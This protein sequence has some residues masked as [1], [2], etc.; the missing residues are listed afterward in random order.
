[1]NILAFDTCFDA[2][3]VAVGEGLGSASPRIVEFY[4]PMVKGQAERLIPMIREALAAASLGMAEIDRIAVTSG[5]GTFTGTRI[6][7]AAAR[8]L[9]LATRCPVVA[10]SSLEVIARHPEIRDIDPSRDLLVAM[11]ANR[12]EAYVQ[13]FAARTRIKLSDP[14]L[15]AIETAAR[16]GAT[17]PILV[18]GSAGEVVAAAAKALGRDAIFRFP[19]MLPR[20]GAMLAR[21]AEIEPL[22]VSL[23]PLYLR[24]P[25][26]KPPTATS[27]P[28]VP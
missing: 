1:M 16:V 23:R 26:A 15:L 18:V 13:H 8:A 25:D 10:F 5:P 20:I 24:A 4:E 14:Q 11:N 22:S 6:G 28:R 17:A 19:A 21:A 3:S 27:L 7:V 12:G 9:A 2:C